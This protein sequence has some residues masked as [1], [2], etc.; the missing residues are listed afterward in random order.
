[1][2][3]QADILTITLNPAVDLATHVAQVI[4]GPKLRCAT[5]QFDP[6]GGGVNV[7]RAI[8]KLDGS[9]RA[10]VA[11]GGPMGQRLT[12]LLTAEHV[13]MVPISFT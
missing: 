8:C 10:L 9:V 13:P 7:A 6:G 4:A 1:M 11:L 12:D 5:P 2:A 3:S